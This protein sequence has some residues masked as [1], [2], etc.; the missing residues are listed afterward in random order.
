MKMYGVWKKS[1]KQ[2]NK[3]TNTWKE[4]VRDDLSTKNPTDLEYKN[5]QG[6]GVMLFTS[7]KAARNK[8]S[9]MFGGE[10]MFEVVEF[11]LLDR[12]VVR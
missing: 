5:R 10:T 2:Y 3:E 12:G 7:E 1:F 8:I 4:V 9:R 6:N 11:D